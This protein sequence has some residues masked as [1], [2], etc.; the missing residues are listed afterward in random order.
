[1]SQEDLY[2]ISKFLNAYL[3][4]HEISSLQIKG[5]DFL[6]DAHSTLGEHADTAVHIA[7]SL[8]YSPPDQNVIV[9][10]ENNFVRELLESHNEKAEAHKIIHYLQNRSELCS[11]INTIITNPTVSV[12]IGIDIDGSHYEGITILTRRYSVGGAALGALGVIGT[13]R[14]PYDRLI[15]AMNYGARMLS[16]VLSRRGEISSD[17]DYIDM[18]ALT[19]LP[20]KTSRKDKGA[21]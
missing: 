2:K 20:N 12:Q 13:S 16:E 8:V 10:G 17:D 6:S 11:L 7:Q 21:L 5:L 18:E 15:P 9:E 19:I 1:L 14:M 4:G 3:P